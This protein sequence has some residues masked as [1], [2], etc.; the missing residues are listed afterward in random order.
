[1][2]LVI[3]NQKEKLDKYKN[4]A[5]SKSAYQTYDGRMGGGH[6]VQPQ[7]QGEP[8]I[9]IQN[10]KNLYQSN[11]FYVESNFEGVDKAR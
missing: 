9:Q 3:K 5:E 2:K 8:G 10:L 11:S 1:M 6:R 7:N 4:A